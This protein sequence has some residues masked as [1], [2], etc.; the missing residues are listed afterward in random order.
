M[1]RSVVCALLVLAL[2]LTAQAADP[3]PGGASRPALVLNDPF[4]AALWRIDVDAD[5]R[6]LVAG[7]P[8]KAA[9]IWSLETFARAA[10]VKR[11][12]IDS[13]ASTK[14]LGT[15]ANATRTA[16]IH[17]ASEVALTVDS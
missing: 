12:R 7:S 17:A 15:M 9:A 2:A 6:F 8:A 16:V 1:R 4:A 3:A 14:T 11:R 13:R 10:F 5:E